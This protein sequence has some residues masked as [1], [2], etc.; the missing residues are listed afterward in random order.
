LIQKEHVSANR[1]EYV[2]QNARFITWPSG[3]H[4]SHVS[5]RLQWRRVN[6]VDWLR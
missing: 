3:E 4:P 1:L 6:D 5:E 2:A